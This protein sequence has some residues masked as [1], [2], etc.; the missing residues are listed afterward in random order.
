MVSS[1]VLPCHVD[2]V[3]CVC[4][5]REQVS[6]FHII[7]SD[8]HIIEGLWEKVVDLPCHIQN[9]AHTEKHTEERIGDIT[10]HVT[11]WHEAMTTRVDQRQCAEL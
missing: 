1:C 3:V 11:Q 5:V 4:P 10:K 6:G 8:V 9:V 2:E 7:H